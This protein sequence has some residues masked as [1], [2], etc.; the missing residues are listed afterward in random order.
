MNCGAVTWI[1]RRSVVGLGLSHVVL[2]QL[3]ET[4]GKR[5]EGVGGRCGYRLGT[6]AV[7]Y[8]RRL[9]GSI[10]LGSRLFNLIP[11]RRRAQF[12]VGA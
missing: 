8:R 12:W 7:A 1:G 2:D 5:V 4:L 11:V 10:L 9:A 6:P 3:A